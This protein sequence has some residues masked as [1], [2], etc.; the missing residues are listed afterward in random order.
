ME[1]TNEALAE[2]NE[3]A[4]LGVEHELEK[5]AVDPRAL[6]AL[7]RRYEAAR[8]VSQG[9]LANNTELR[10]ANARLVDE[11][12]ETTMDL[13]EARNT[14]QVANCRHFMLARR[15]EGLA[16]KLRR[17]STAS[18]GPVHRNVL[19]APVPELGDA[20]VGGLSPKATM[21]T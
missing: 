10:A 12:T 17:L 16:M 20:P 3:M 6:A 8:G 14:A 4:K 5:V 15:V 1:L 11:L 9:M 13:Y 7:L 21:R 19:A 2:L 18:M